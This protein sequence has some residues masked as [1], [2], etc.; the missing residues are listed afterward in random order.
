MK[1]LFALVVLCSL[2]FSSALCIPHVSFSLGDLSSFDLDEQLNL[3]YKAK[4][5]N[6]YYNGTITETMEAIVIVS[7]NDK[8]FYYADPTTAFYFT[9]YGS[10]VVVPPYYCESIPYSYYKDI[11]KA[12]LGIDQS[13]VMNVYYFLR[14]ETFYNYY[15]IILLTFLPNG[16]SITVNEDGIWQSLA[17]YGPSYD[18]QE[19]YGNITQSTYSIYEY[20]PVGSY[21][22][23]N[24]PSL[25]S[26]CPR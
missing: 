23:T 5:K 24:I 7:P 20:A 19:L 26:Y 1:S 3:A 9:N 13:G 14:K 18:F 15:G 12:F 6:I 4:L 21:E 8:V 2:A 17:F 16:V 22:W 11:V 25:P 10:Y